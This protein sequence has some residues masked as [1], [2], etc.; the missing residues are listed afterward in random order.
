MKITPE[1][2]EHIGGLL[3]HQRGN[4][5]LDNLAVLSA[6]PHVMEHGCKWRALPERFGNWHTI[7]TRMSR[8]SSKGVLDR[9]FVELQRRGIVRIRVEAASLDSTAVKVH[10]DGTGALKK[11]GAQ[12]IGKSRGGWT[13]RRSLLEGSLGDGVS[14]TQ[15]SPHPVLSVGGLHERFQATAG[16]ILVLGESHISVK[17]WDTWVPA[18]GDADASRITLRV[19]GVVGGALQKRNSLSDP[20]V[21][22]DRDVGSPVDAA[23]YSFGLSELHAGK[24]GFLAG[25]GTNDITFTIQAE[26]DDEN[27]SD[28][29]SDNSGEQPANVRIPVV[30]LEEFIVGETSSVNSDGALTPDVATLDLWRGTAAGGTLTIFVELHRGESTEELLLESGVASIASSWSWDAQSGIGTLF[31]Q[32]SSP[33]SV[34]DFRSVLGFL[35]LRSA[36]GVSEGYRRILVRPDISGSAFRKDFHM[37]EVEV[38]GND[39]PQAPAAGLEKHGVDEDD[40]SATYHFPAFT[41]EEDDAVGKSLRYGAQLVVGGSLVPFHRGSRSTRIRGL[42]RLLRS[43]VI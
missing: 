31:L 39:A 19:R 5:S 30:G 40:A 16:R 43:L 22:I 1:Q 35:Q 8:W 26:D 10:P 36:V 29:D 34:S 14:W 18:T 42:L 32:G 25:D 7:Y 33:V 13:I 23:V 12:A 3:P 6:I 37:R 27:L 11:N 9:V 24:I 28:S 21:A 4:V 15:L 38:S 41:D 2:Y 20:W 17:D